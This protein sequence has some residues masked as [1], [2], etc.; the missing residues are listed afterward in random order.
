MLTNAAVALFSDLRSNEAELS[1]KAVHAMAV[2]NTRELLTAT[3]DGGSSAQQLTYECFVQDLVRL[4]LPWGYVHG[5][6]VELLG[7][8]MQGFVL[9]I[10]QSGEPF[11]DPIRHYL[12]AREILR[13]PRAV[14][15]FALAHPMLLET[16]QSHADRLCVDLLEQV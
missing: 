3:K 12:A 2:R 9:Q 4:C 13:M 14:E 15:R 10:Q 8:I 5:D 7:L 16:P 11:R 6:S 1:A